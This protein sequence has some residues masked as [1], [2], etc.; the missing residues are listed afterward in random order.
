MGERRPV[1]VICGPTASGKT[2]LAVELALRLGGEIISADSMQIYRE[3]NIG[4]AKP[5]M[6]E[7]R[8]V[9]HHMLDVASV[10]ENYSVSRYESEGAEAVEGVMARGRQPIVCGGTGLYIN[11]LIK[12]SG[13]LEAD[14]SGAV[15]ASLEADWDRLGAEG[16]LSRL[17]A[18]DPES[19][20]RL[21]IND[22]KRIIRALEV[23]EITGRTITSHNLETQSRPPRYDSIFIGITPEDRHVLYDR[24]DRRVDIMME[25]GLLEEVKDLYGRGLMINTAAQAIGYKEL[26]GY[27]KGESSL[28]E[29]VELIKRKSRNYAKRQLTWFGRDGRVCW[30]KYKKD[31]NIGNLVE[32]S[33]KYLSSKGVL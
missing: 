16:M 13:F 3:L 4:T 9:P 27:L 1:I 2:A 29:S 25:R 10:R 23:F 26:L 14:E 19:A 24:I 11:A 17:G 12:G 15:R 21:H 31:E 32:A 20:A 18:V 6:A 33:T 28:E 7:R 30:I 5:D 22:K 8:G